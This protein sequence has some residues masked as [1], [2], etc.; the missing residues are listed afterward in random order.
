ME[1][2]IVTDEN[3]NTIIQVEDATGNVVEEPKQYEPIEIAKTEE[4]NDVVETPVEPDPVPVEPEYVPEPDP[5]PVEPA[6]EPEPEPEAPV[7][8]ESSSSGY[9]PFKHYY[10]GD[11]GVVEATWDDMIPTSN[12]YIYYYSDRGV[13]YEY[14]IFNES[15]DTCVTH[16]YCSTNNSDVIVPNLVELNVKYLKYLNY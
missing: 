12:K 5:T 11:E 16:T 15:L 8:S 2:T 9:I 10:F 4:G 7:E 1:G 13:G 3:G 6:P 14:C